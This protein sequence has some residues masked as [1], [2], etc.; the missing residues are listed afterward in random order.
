MAVRFLVKLRPDRY[1][2]IAIVRPNPFYMMHKPTVLST[3]VN[4]ID[5]NGKRG[6]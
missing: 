4:K 1:M 2:T 5:N 3:K 6:N